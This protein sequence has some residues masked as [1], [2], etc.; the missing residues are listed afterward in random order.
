MSNKSTQ[1][2]EYHFL[3]ITKEDINTHNTL[4]KRIRNNKKLVIKYAAKRVNKALQEMNH[5]T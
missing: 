2:I 3:G 4:V 1:A 5:A